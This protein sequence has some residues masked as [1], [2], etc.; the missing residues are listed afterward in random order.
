MRGM[1]V[2]DPHM[3]ALNSGTLEAIRVIEWVSSRYRTFTTLDAA[4]ELEVLDTSARRHLVALDVA[5]WI[6]RV[7][8]GKDGP[9]GVTPHGYRTIK[10]IRAIQ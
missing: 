9:N 8:G 2:A 10:R 5:G 6:K 7:D 1:K 4:A 3:R